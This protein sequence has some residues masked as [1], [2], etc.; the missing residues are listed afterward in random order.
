MSLNGELTLAQALKINFD[1]HQFVGIL[2]MPNI[3][4]KNINL[5]DMI[6]AYQNHDATNQEILQWKTEGHIRIQNKAFQHFKEQTAVIILPYP[7]EFH[8]SKKMCNILQMNMVSPQDKTELEY[9]SA[10]L[11][12]NSTICLRNYVAQV[13]LDYQISLHTRRWFTSN[14]TLIN[15]FDE[16]IETYK[17]EQDSHLTVTPSGKVSPFS[18][19][20]S[21]RCTMCI[22]K[23]QDSSPLYLRGLCKS[24]VFFYKGSHFGMNYIS[25]MSN[26]GL[27]IALIDRSWTLFHTET[28]TTIATLDSKHFAI[29]RKM[30]LASINFYCR[31]LPGI[32]FKDNKERPR[33]F[34]LSN[35]NK[36]QF[37][38]NDGSCISIIKRCDGT[39]DCLDNSDEETCKLLEIPH[40]KVKK[41]PLVQPFK[42]YFKAKIQKVI[43]FLAI[44]CNVC[45]ALKPTQ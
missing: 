9:Y 17:F 14:K 23:K 4:I 7:E 44:Q 2:S 27:A 10:H 18:T 45:L 13:W 32:I 38:C 43:L 19:R 16:T 20:S 1:I 33:L 25:F 41:M 12:K 15:F 6:K 11:N 5:K 8:Q 24:D 39:L 21:R 26:E 40:I 28:K 3:W 37:T 31:H 42:I 34:I 30:W 22:N 29:G 36:N 35:C